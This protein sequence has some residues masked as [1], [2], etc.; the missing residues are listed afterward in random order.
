MHAIG[1][2][3]IEWHELDIQKPQRIDREYKQQGF[4]EEFF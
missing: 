3:I 2:A 4:E 1:A